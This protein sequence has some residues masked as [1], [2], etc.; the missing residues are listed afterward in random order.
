MV[1]NNNSLDVIRITLLLLKIR[2][3]IF[4]MEVP[5]GHNHK[6]KVFVYEFFGT[7]VL[8][9]AVLASGGDLTAVALTVLALIVACA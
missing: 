4:S 3:K 5:G 8:V 6:G 7:S 2:N 9:Y 1:I